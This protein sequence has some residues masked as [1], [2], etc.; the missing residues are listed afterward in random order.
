MNIVDYIPY[1][2]ENAIQRDALVLLTGVKDRTVRKAISKARRTTPILNMQEG[3]GYYRPTKDDAM[4][5]RRY[6]AQEERR[7]KSIFFSLRAAR[8]AVKRLGG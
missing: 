2:K 6:V 8:Q 7:A 5:L 4:E 1:G 3:N